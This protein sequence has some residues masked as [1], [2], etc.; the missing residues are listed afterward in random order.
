MLRPTVAKIKLSSLQHNVSFAKSIAPRTKL[1]AVIK[2]DAYGHGAVSVA[3]ALEDNVEA[4][5]VASLDEAMELRDHK[6]S[7]PILILEGVF[8]P[9]DIK[10]CSSNDITIAVHSRN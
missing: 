9:E 2:A 4:F 7:I 5:A 1:M 10:T 6:I 3:E 8:S